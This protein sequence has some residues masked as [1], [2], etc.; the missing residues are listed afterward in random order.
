MQEILA[1]AVEDPARVFLERGSVIEV[2]TLSPEITPLAYWRLGRGETEV[3]EYAR[4]HTGIVA[5][6]DDLSA[7]RAAVALGVPVLGTL[8]LLA[9]AFK[10]NPDAFSDDAVTRLRSAGLHVSDKVVAEVEA[11]LRDG[12]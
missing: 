1:G 4:L 9:L 2:V 7:R 12:Y 5:L 11:R 8:G 3:I 10:D 6:L